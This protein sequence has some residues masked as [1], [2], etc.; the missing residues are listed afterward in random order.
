QDAR[1]N[2]VLSEV[3]DLFCDLEASDAQTDFP[4]IY[5]IGKL[6]IAKRELDDPSED[7]VPL[8][9]TILDKVPSPPGEAEE[10][11]QIIVCNLAHDDYGGK[12]A[13]GRVV[14]GTIKNGQNV[15][16]L[17]DGK[18]S[19]ANVKMLYTFEGLKRVACESAS[20]GENVAIAGFEEVDIGDTIA[21]P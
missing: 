11:L 6:G 14:G 1:P 18:T 21:I 15:V 9:E 10:P 13:G 4:V 20:A 12:V 8:F 17:G 7:L 3:F 5:A 16:I 2:D 19:P